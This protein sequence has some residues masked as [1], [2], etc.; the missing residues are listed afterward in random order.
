V[1]KW[2]LRVTGANWARQQNLGIIFFEGVTKFGSGAETLSSLGQRD[3]MRGS[4][5]LAPISA[6]A[7]FLLVKSR[8]NNDPLTAF[9]SLTM[10]LYL[11]TSMWAPVVRSSATMLTARGAG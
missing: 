6:A 5:Q 1:N 3:P 2:K 7:I 4:A 11:T 9:D 10:P 8:A